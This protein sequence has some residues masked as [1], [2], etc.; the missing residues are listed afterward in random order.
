MRIFFTLKVCP[1]FICLNYSNYFTEDEFE[2]IEKNIHV[3]KYI[4]NMS[5]ASRCVHLQCIYSLCVFLCPHSVSL[6]S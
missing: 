4:L 3:K 5:I 2:K 6:Q 1:V